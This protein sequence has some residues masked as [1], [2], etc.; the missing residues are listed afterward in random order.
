MPI[1][2]DCALLRAQPKYNISAVIIVNGVPTAVITDNA[3]RRVDAVDEPSSAD[4]VAEVAPS[5]PGCDRLVTARGLIPT[6]GP[7]PG[8]RTGPPDALPDGMAGCYW[9]VVVHGPQ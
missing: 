1:H 7:T 4:V 8:P 6:R 2:L 9:A 3:D 5:G